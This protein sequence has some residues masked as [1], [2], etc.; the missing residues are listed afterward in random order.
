M[1]NPLK[2]DTKSIALIKKQK[3]GTIV[4]KRDVESRHR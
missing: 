1:A 3:D 4:L 2:V